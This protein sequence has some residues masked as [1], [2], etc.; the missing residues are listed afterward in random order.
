MDQEQQLSALIERIYEASLDPESWGS[1]L[2]DMSVFL[3]S[4]SGVV[5]VPNLNTGKSD[6]N[7]WNTNWDSNSV[8]AHANYYGEISTNFKT[9]S[10][11]PV[12]KVFADHMVRDYNVYRNS[13]AYNDFFVPLKREHLLNLIPQ[14]G[15]QKQVSLTFRRS[16]SRGYFSDD[17]IAKLNL[18]SPHITQSFRIARSLDQEKIKQVSLTESLEF[19]RDAIFILD[20]KGQLSYLNKRAQKVIDERDGF[21]LGANGTPRAAVQ[22][23]STHMARVVWGVVTNGGDTSHS[24]GGVFHISRISLRRPY[25]A[26]V[27]P[28][29]KTQNEME[30]RAGA[31][32]VIN[33][34]DGEPETSIEALQIFYGLTLAEAN[35]LATFVKEASIELTGERL[36]ITKNTA[37]T[38]MKLV[39]AKTG[40]N[41]QASLMKLILTGPITLKQ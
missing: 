9:L 40:V 32:L 18:L 20:E 25:Q 10:T 14:R 33:D 36:G 21:I 24:P 37:R 12:G 1:L 2:D 39:F 26:M 27:A 16:K 5:Y 11:Y 30:G 38:Y 17:E 15:K 7:L 34:P 28:L 19:S 3:N 13:E 29:P 35:F 8:H 22:T 4:E 41:N 23:E 6:G 31:I